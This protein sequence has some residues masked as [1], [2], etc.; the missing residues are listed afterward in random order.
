MLWILTIAI[1]LH[2]WICRVL[3]SQPKKLH[4]KTTNCYPSTGVDL[5]RSWMKWRP[6][7]SGWR[8]SATPR[9]PTTGWPSWSCGRSWQRTGSD[10]RNWIICG[11]LRLNLFHFHPYLGLS[12]VGKFLDT[13]LDYLVRIFLLQQGPHLPD[14]VV[15]YLI[16]KRSGLFLKART[17]VS[18][19]QPGER[20]GGGRNQKE[21]I[22]RANGSAQGYTQVGW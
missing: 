13:C 1:S 7:R 21:E 9:P 20:E 16:P 11:H 3:S 5:K 2:T 4:S 19:R 12:S 22:T 14:H 10:L 18:Q 6:R 8:H 17:R 15:S